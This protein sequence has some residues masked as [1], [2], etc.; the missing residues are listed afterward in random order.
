MERL[1][2]WLKV[3]LGKGEHYRKVRQALAAQGL[4]TVCSGARCPN[5]GEC[6]SAGTATF[7]I[8]GDRC[9]RNCRFCAVPHE[10]PDGLD[11]EEPV[12]VARAVRELGLSYSVVTS[13]TRDDLP[14][15]GAEVFAATIRAIRLEVPGCRVE[16]LIP[17]FQGDFG[18]LKT[19][20]SAD[21]DVL[22]HNVETV[23]SLYS[24]VRPQADYRRSLTLL[25]RAFEVLGRDRVKSGLMLGMGETRAELEVVF[26]D[27]LDAGV[28]RLTLGQ[29]LQPTR[30]HMPVHRYVPPDE[31]EELGRLA[32]DMGFWAVASGPLVRSSYHAAEMEK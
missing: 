27:L 23:P 6:W 9:T 2:S 16:V 17:D 26:Q 30:E 7:M 20:L 11:E 18:A 10:M 29:Y 21:P 19:V 31:F 28:G 22:N 1:P 5:L 12:R 15:G 25:H 14:D 4:H 3:T 32:E 8:L 24:Q 13:V